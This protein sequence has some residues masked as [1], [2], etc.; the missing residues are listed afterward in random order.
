MCGAGPERAVRGERRPGVK[1][2][3]VLLSPALGRGEAAAGCKT[4]R[5]SDLGGCTLSGLLGGTELG[6]EKSDVEP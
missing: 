6:R 3:L 2:R 5:V 4:R 1:P